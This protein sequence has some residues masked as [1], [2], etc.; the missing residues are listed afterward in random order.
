MIYLI[1]DNQN[2][3]RLSNYNITFIEEGAFDEYLISIDKLEIG[4]SF[5]STSHLDFLKNADC[6]LL[7]TT[8]E[9]FLP[10]KGF[11][12]GSKTNVLK[13]KEIISQEGELIPIV[14][15]SNSMGETEYNSD[16][17]PNYISSIKKNLFYERLFDF[18]ENYKNS[19]I[20]DLRI[21]AWGSNFA[22]K[23]VSR[24]AIEILSAFESKDNSD[25]LK[26]S[27]LSPIIKS[28]KTFL[29]LSFSNS[30]VNEILNDIEDNP[31]RIKEFK[32]KIKHITEC[33]A[34]YGKNTCNWKQ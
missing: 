13:I 33:Y 18:L 34:K 31:I 10:G 3:Q 14:L 22:C 15:F 32:D 6:I 21:I 19:G 20:V 8:T 27:D 9:D 29:E 1:D 30:K 4:S 23:E 16:K 28:F 25:R 24:L 17:N 11:I 5:S 12:P 26:L 2:N 7:H